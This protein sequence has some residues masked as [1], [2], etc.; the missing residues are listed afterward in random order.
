[1]KFKTTPMPLTFQAAP[2]MKTLSMKFILQSF[3]GMIQQS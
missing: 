3:S 2:V 1:M